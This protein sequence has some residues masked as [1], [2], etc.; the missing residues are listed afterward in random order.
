MQ[1]R[2]HDILRLRAEGKTYTEIIKILG[3][4]SGVVAYHCGIGQKAKT[5]A[6]TNARR[7]NNPLIRKLESFQQRQHT[8]KHKL[9]TSKDNRYIYLHIKNFFRGQKMDKAF[10]VLDVI[11][12]IGHEPKCYL[13]G[14]PIDLTK[15]RTYNFDHIIP[16]SRGGD[17]SINN[18]GVCTREANQAKND[19][20]PDEFLNLCKQV[21][22]HH[23]YEVKP[24]VLP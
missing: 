4:S 3:C 10:T 8:I 1:S 23:G 7:K 2:K 12:K 13:T 17:N 9:D 22:E 11:N 19:M 20:T 24:I 6:R 18:L 5:A 14:R 15:S 21:L 16:A